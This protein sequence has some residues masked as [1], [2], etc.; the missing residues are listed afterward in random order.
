MPRKLHPYTM[1]MLAVMVNTTGEATYEGFDAWRV[2]DKK[3]REQII[4]ALERKGYIEPSGIR[5]IPTAKG[6]ALVLGED[7]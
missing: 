2:G 7:K 5:M 1:R 3:A 6:R 4:L